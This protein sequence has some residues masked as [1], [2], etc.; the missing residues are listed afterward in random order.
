MFLEYLHSS[1]F[2]SIASLFVNR[3][4]VASCPFPYSSRKKS[5]LFRSTSRQH[6]NC[7]LP[8]PFDD[9]L[10]ATARLRQSIFS[11]LQQRRCM[12]GHV[13]NN[14]MPARNSNH[15]R[16]KRPGLL[17]GCGRRI[18]Y[19][20]VYGE[21]SVPH[22]YDDSCERGFAGRGVVLSYVRRRSRL[23]K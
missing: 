4:K 9:D 22:G 12:H 19:H 11:V 17:P 23:Q 20:T 5:L 3:S 14:D 2:N 10:Y 21:P 16:S 8:T 15:R 7:Y 1:C 13:P 18:S 6:G